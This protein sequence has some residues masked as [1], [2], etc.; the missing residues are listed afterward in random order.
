M[1]GRSLVLDGIDLQIAQGQIVGLLGSNGVGKTTLLKCLAGLLRPTTG[2]VFWFGKS[3]QRN[4][5]IRSHVGFSGHESFLYPELSAS[6]NLLFA[7]RMHGLADPAVRTRETIGRIGLELH[8]SSPAGH[9][10]KGLRQRL[11]IARALVHEPLMVILDEPF[12]GLDESGREWLEGCLV[13][14]KALGR[15]IVF[16]SHDEPFAHHLADRVLELRSGRL[17]ARPQSTFAAAAA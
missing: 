6:E 1:L 8:S 2:A 17:H 3:P 10:S 15:A 9:L 13:D 4:T 12:S 16:T 11:S 7:A 5:A 14:L